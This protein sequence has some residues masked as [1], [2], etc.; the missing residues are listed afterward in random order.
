MQVS[1]P[2]FLK[3]SFDFKVYIYGIN[4]VCFKSLRNDINTQTNEDSYIYR[5]Q[6]YKNSLRAFKFG[7]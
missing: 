5:R 2:L 6:Q 3:V 1:L 7:I 4:I